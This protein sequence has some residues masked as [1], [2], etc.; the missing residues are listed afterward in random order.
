MGKAETT[1]SLTQALNW[2]VDLKHPELGNRPV[3][4]M[5]HAM[6]GDEKLLAKSLDFDEN[7]YKNIVRRIDLQQIA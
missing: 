3:I 6:K 5:G 2:P 7:V 1:F 4:F